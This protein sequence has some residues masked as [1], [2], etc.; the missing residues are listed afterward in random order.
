MQ[1]AA[2][3]VIPLAIVLLWNLLSLPTTAPLAQIQQII[4]PEGDRTQTILPD[5]TRIWLNSGTTMGYD[6]LQF[7][8][9]SRVVS[10]NGEAYFE[11]ANNAGLPFKVVTDHTDVVVTGTAFNVKA[12]P[13]S[14]IFELILAEGSLTLFFKSDNSEQLDMVP[15]QQL[16][17]N[18]ETQK[19]VL[20]QV[21]AEMLTTWRTG[22]LIFRDAT[23]SELIT[24][25]ENIHAI[26]FNLEQESLGNYRFRG[27]IRID[28]NLIEVLDKIEKTS[29]IGYVIENQTVLLRKHN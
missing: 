16:I 12:L 23:L 28:N 2:A 29:G 18:A 26:Q 11:V 3:V 17:Y 6:A 22:E 4:A 14:P 13:E 24:A 27:M 25:L 15:N 8:L 9:H 21:D 20:N 1:L 7:N 5:G 19:K 10:L